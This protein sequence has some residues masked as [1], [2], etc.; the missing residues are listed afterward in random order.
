MVAQSPNL[1]TPTKPGK[2][3]QEENVELIYV[4]EKKEEGDEELLVPFLLDSMFDRSS[5]SPTAVHQFSDDLCCQGQEKTKCSAFPGHL[6]MPTLGEALGDDALRQQPSTLGEGSISYQ[7]LGDD[8]LRQQPSFSSSSVT[9]PVDKAHPFLF[10]EDI[11][12]EGDVTFQTSSYD[13]NINLAPRPLD[14]AAR[15]SIFSPNSTPRNSQRLEFA[16]I[17]EKVF[18][19]G[20]YGGAEESKEE[21]DDDDR[22]N[23]EEG[24]TLSY[25]KRRSE[26]EFWH[27]LH[28]GFGTQGI[29]KEGITHRLSSIFD[30]RKS[31]TESKV[32][33]FIESFMNMF[34]CGEYGKHYQS[35]PLVSVPSTNSLYA[36][37][38][39]PIDC[40]H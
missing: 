2:D 38:C 39:R 17:D 24:S 34:A 18:S 15:A 32:E 10:P 5:P 31:E 3:F 4:S 40:L 33:T 35:K 25:G 13:R 1:K 21:K 20:S 27:D 19:F 12:Y 22:A 23:E 8:E 14:A 30:P 28:K 16:Y 29:G 36:E 37:Q 7:D 9:I 6:M 11:R 26:D